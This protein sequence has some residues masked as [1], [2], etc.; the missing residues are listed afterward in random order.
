MGI[1]ATIAL[2]DLRVML[3]EKETLLWLFFMPPVF[4][5]FLGTV[6]GGFGGGGARKDEIAV[7]V[8]ADAGFLGERV[9]AA[10]EREKLAVV[11]CT[12][13]A[14]LQPYDRQLTLPPDLTGKVQRG[15]RAELVWRREPDDGPGPEQDR[16]RV[17]R[18]AYTLLADVVVAGVRH[19]GVSEGALASLDAAPRHVTL[20]VAPAGERPVI[21][22]GFA[23]AVPGTLVMFTLMILLTSGGITLVLDRRQGLLRRLASAPVSRRDVVLGKAV[24]RVGLAV[25]QIAFGMTIGT[26]LFAMD[27]GPDLPM[28]CVVLLVWAFLCAMLGLLAGNVAR[29]EGQ[30]VALGIVGSMVL[31]ALGGCWWPI[32]IVPEWMQ[33]LASCLPTGWTMQ[34]LHQLVT[35]RNGPASALGDLALLLAAGVAAAWAAARTFRY[36]D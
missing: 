3:R 28:L 21:P 29:S 24:A 16:I 32:E 27:W 5:W 1:V 17:A 11:R 36:Q 23:Q 8:P 35:F 7:L 26:L 30:A 9:C 18:V 20:N 10:L 12:D 31:A 25:L 13:A 4:F 33:T 14:A 34:A 15:E 6:T 2:Q 22:T 19:G